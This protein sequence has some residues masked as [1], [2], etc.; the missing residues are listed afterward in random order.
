MRDH[1][2]TLAKLHLANPEQVHQ[3]IQSAEDAKSGRLPWEQRASVLLKAAALLAGPWRDRVNAS[4]MLGQAKTV[5]Q[6][7]I[8]AACE[9]IDF[10]DLTRVMPEKDLCGTAANFTGRYLESRV[11]H[12]PLDGFVPAV[13]PFNFTSI[14]LNLCTAPALMGNT[15]VWKPSNTSALSCWYLMRSRGRGS[16]RWRGEHGQWPWRRC[17]RYCLGLKPPGR[18]SFHWLY[19]EPF[20]TCGARLATTFRI[21]SSTPELLVRREA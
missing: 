16:P 11:D 1:G 3:A 19:V 8:D 4:T 17:W 20:S 6:A 2:H 13:A 5:H 7:E 21:I 10:G 15:T 9:L 12:R 18:H 14:A